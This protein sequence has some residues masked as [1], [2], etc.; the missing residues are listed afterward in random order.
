[1]KLS[2]SVLAAVVL[3]LLAAACVDL[4]HSTNATS[5]CDLDAN[6]PGCEGG[7]PGEAGR[8]SLC[9]PDAGVAQSEALRAC[10]WLSACEHPVGRNAMGAC[11]VDAILAYDCHTNPDRMPRATAAAFWQCMLVVKTCTDV[12]KCVMPDGLSSCMNGGFIG[13]SNGANP[14]TRF[15]CV[16][17][18]PEGGVAAAE[19]CVMAAQTCDSQD[20]DASNHGAL[21]VGPQGEHCSSSLGCQGTA[22][23][24]CD[25][26]GVDHGYDCADLGLGVCDI[27]NSACTPTPD[28]DNTLTCL[29]GS[30]NDVTCLGDK[31]IGCATGKAEQ[32]VCTA[33]SGAGTCNPIEGGTGTVPSDGCFVADGGCATDTCDDA[34]FTA[35]VR[36]RSVPI[37]CNALG[38]GTCAQIATTEGTFPACTPP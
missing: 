16:T 26:A 18:T 28:T 21:C 7:T 33:L 6:A 35:C 29:S 8:P 17:P 24:F 19:N 27:G 22:L 4:F 23:S 5:L 9:A 15:D 31:A 10:G 30:S 14:N 13:C 34:G 2:R 20:R 37:D 3:V 11:M 36:G 38:L 1:M 12:A 25:D 32:V